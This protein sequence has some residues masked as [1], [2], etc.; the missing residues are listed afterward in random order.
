MLSTSPGVTQVSLPETTFV[1]VSCCAL[2]ILILLCARG[3]WPSYTF[4]SR[5]AKSKAVTRRRDGLG[6]VLQV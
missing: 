3:R 6:V 5:L 4:G 2:L 1:G